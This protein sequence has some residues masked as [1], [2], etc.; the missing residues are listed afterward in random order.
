[1]QVGVTSVAIAWCQY[2]TLLYLPKAVSFVLL[3]PDAHTSIHATPATFTSTRGKNLQD[4]SWKA[5]DD[6]CSSGK[7]ACAAH[8]ALHA[9]RRGGF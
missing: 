5:R 7:L 1:M 8:A 4:G 6:A 2:S 9:L 3:T